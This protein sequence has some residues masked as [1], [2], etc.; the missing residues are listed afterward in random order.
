MK[1]PDAAGNEPWVISMNGVHSFI[2]FN[3]P[4][5]WCTITRFLN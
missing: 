2:G 1:Y 4:L 5:R 3:L